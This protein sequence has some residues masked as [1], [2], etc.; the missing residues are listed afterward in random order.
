MREMGVLEAKTAFSSIVSDVERTGEEVVITRYGKAAVRISRA[1]HKES[2]TDREAVVS[3]I[4]KR[5]DAH[6]RSD[7]SPAARE[8]E[9]ADLLDRDRDDE[10]S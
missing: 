4:L 8:A 9:L 2:A 7:N 6:P 3:R 5:L 1:T 10:W